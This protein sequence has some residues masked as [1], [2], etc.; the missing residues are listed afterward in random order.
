MKPNTLLGGIATRLLQPVES[1]LKR[2]DAPELVGTLEGVARLLQRLQS[3]D[4]IDPDHPLNHRVGEYLSD[5]LEL[6]R[7]LT[8]PDHSKP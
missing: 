3:P 2:M 4:I 1:T 7:I 5:V 8:T 6:T